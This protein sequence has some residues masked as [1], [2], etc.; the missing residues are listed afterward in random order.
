MAQLRRDTAQFAEYRVQIG[1]FSVAGV[2]ETARFC[3]SQKLDP[4]FV[5]LSDPGLRAYQAFGLTKGGLG[6]MLSPRVLLRGFLG[7]LHGYVSTLPVGDPRQLS[8]VAIVDATGVVRYHYRSRDIAD[9][10]PN[11]ELFETLSV[12]AVPD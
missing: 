2:E 3:A 5:C 8:G 12:L 7:L 1:L 11:A 10:P 6:A 4:L 9:N